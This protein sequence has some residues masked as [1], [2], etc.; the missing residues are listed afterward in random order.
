MEVLK[1]L[2][3]IANIAKNKGISEPF[4][5]GGLPRDKVLGVVDRALDIDLTTGDDSIDLLAISTAQ[6]LI[7]VDPNVNLKVFPDGHSQININGIKI[8]FSSNFR[9]KYANEVMKKA[10]INNPPKMILELISRDFTCNTLLL[11]LDLKKI[12]DPLGMGINDIKNKIL[13]TPL[14]PQYT[15]SDDNKRIVRVIYLASKLNFDVEEPILKW[16]SANTHLLQNVKEK[17]IIDKINESID[18]NPNK[19]VD[20]LNKMNLWKNIPITD[21]LMPYASGRF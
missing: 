3:L 9:S 5:V 1:L 8:D 20:L 13:K 6:E 15:L 7:K 10:G 14:P 2:Q 12:K 11:S 19:T 18:K 4:I 21:K 16:V 17:Y